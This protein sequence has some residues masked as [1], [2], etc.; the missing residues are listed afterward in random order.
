MAYPGFIVIKTAQVGIS[1]TS[2]PSKMNLDKKELLNG[3][4]VSTFFQQNATTFLV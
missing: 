2:L 1:F 3:E 4:Y